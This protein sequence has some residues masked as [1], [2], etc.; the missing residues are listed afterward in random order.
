[1][2]NE[3]LVLKIQAG[4]NTSANMEQLYLRNRSYIYQQAKKYSVYADMD[5]LMQEAYF[6]L[7]DAVE[8][9]DSQKEY[10][11]I[12]YLT[13]RLNNRFRR[14]I[15]NCGRAKR[16]PTHTLQLIYK[17][18]KYLANCAKQGIEPTDFAICRDLGL[19][20]K[21]LKNLRKTILEEKCISTDQPIPGTDNIRIEDEIPDPLD[22]EEDVLD[23]VAKEQ[24]EARIW[25]IV[26]ELEEQQKTVIIGRYKNSSTLGEIGRTMNLS[27]ERVRQIERKAL[28]ILSNKREIENIA[29][30]YGY[31]NPY[32]GTGFQNF[33]NTGCSSV[34]FAAMRNI[35]KE[36]RIKALQQCISDSKDE[37]KKILNPNELFEQVLNLAKN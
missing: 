30:I 16:I 7:M 3:E 21:R 22:M 36:E 11:F 4:E 29:E 9:F 34:E 23:L 24:A 32:K 8:H 20:E 25:E 14:Y 18:K 6:G 33:K 35:E 27:T 12:T 26:L 17:Y 37:I 5:D 2:E 19:T 15:D 31:I 10:K 13:Y 28:S 1:M